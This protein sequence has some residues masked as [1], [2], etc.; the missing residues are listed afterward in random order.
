MAEYIERGAVRERACAGC[1]RRIGEDGCGFDEPCGRLVAEFVCA[2]AADVVEVVHGQWITEDYDS[3]E[4]ES[5]A[6][7]ICV[8]CS[9]CRYSLGAENGEYG[10]YY[11][12]PFPLKYCP[13]CGARMDGDVQ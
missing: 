4:P 10:W 9:K 3:G 12:D 2:P 1:T 13:N 5:Y 7:F 11:G 8:Q 6:A